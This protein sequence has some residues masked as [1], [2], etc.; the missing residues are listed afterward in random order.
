MQTKKQSRV[1]TGIQQLA[2]FLVVLAS[3]MVLFPIIGLEVS[4]IGNVGI[5]IYFTIISMARSY[6]IRRY[7]NKKYS[8]V[9]NDKIK[10]LKAC[11]SQRDSLILELQREY[12]KIKREEGVE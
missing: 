2:G 3:Q 5:T 9:N 11:V 4:L 10:I 1:E 7:F 8:E 12:Y 6:I